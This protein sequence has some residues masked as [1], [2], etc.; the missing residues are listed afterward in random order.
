[1]ACS[2]DAVLWIIYLL[3]R[4]TL[5]DTGIAVRV[6]VPE[7][8]GGFMIIIVAAHLRKRVIWESA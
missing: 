3:N 6:K 1:M 2:C 7:R 4:T 8:P 5:K